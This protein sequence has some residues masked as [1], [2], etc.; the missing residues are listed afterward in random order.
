MMGK[1]THRFVPLPLLLL[2]LRQHAF[3]LG[4][5]GQHGEAGEARRDDDAQ[6]ATTPGVS[7]VSII[8]TLTIVLVN[9]QVSCNRHQD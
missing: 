5:E 2:L 1:E 9:H 3:I 7:I 8:V 4:E 6:L